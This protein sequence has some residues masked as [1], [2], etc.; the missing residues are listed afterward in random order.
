[1]K[2][3]LQTLWM[4]SVPKALAEGLIPENLRVL[5]LA[6]HPDDFDAIGVTLRFLSENGNP[7]HV[8]VVRTGSGVDDAYH[9]G[10]TL[11][12]KADLREKEQRASLR[13]FGLAEGSLSFLELQRDNSDQLQDCAA[14]FN[15][16]MSFILDRAPDIIFLPH[17]NDTNHAHRIMCSMVRQTAARDGRPMAL[18]LNRDAKTVA[19]RTDLYLPFGDEMAEWK[20]QLLRCHDSQQQRN[21]AT[22]GHGFDQR[23]LMLNQ[24]IARELGLDAPY[25]EAFE[26]E[27]YNLAEK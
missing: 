25:A 23:V 17:G 22:R 7:I 21:L 10:A 26:L 3:E 2:S 20:A 4:G 12:Q 24:Q 9:P 1:M 5:V 13:L 15:A 14:N 11:A 19:M 16:I 8:A 27:F 6:P 18:F